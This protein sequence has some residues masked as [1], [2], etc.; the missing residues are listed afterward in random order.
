MSPRTTIPTSEL[1]TLLVPW[2]ARY[3]F[4]GLF[5]EGVAFG[6]GDHRGILPRGAQRALLH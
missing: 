5:I 6:E 2:R 1:V 3:F 4:A